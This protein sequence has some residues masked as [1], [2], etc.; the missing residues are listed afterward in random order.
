MYTGG[1]A[2][3]TSSNYFPPVGQFEEWHGRPARELTR[4]MRV[5]PQT[6]LLLLPDSGVSRSR[7]C[8]S[9]RTPDFNTD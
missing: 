2:L 1:L 8:E 4:K 7:R 5:P 9:Q 3:A 6:D